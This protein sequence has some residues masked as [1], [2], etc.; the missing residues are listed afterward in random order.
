MSVCCGGADANASITLEASFEGSK[1][2]ATSRACLD[3]LCSNGFG[4]KRFEFGALLIREWHLLLLTSATEVATL[5]DVS[6]D[7]SGGP[8]DLIVEG[9]T[10][11]GDI[12]EDRLF[13]LNCGQFARGITA[14]WPR[15]PC[16]G[17]PQRDS[18]VRFADP[19]PETTGQTAKTASL[20]LWQSGH[21]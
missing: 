18:P 11:N 21:G 8:H 3:Q 9:D 15:L 10:V 14:G 13:T 17:L 16:G 5:H 4:A 6:D 1:R 19:V 7:M 12:L 2:R 20:A